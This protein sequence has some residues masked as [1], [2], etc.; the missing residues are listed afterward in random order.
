VTPY[1]FVTIFN[2]DFN[3]LY[4][5]FLSLLIVWLSPWL[6]IYV[7]DWAL[8]KG[9][10]DPVALL[11]SR[12]G[13]YWR[14]NGFNIPGVVAQ[15]AGMAAS[16]LWIDSTAFVGPLSSR[17]SGSDFSFF[18]GLL[19]GGLVYFLLGRRGKG[20]CCPVPGGDRGGVGRSTGYLRAHPKL[21]P[22]G[23]E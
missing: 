15:L 19:V 16:C 23:H 8:R 12:G 17:T 14:Q 3:R 11:Q 6:A 4:S 18:T 1:L 20:R 9:K 2:S 5:E 10:Y 13:R 7:I 21:R 22:A